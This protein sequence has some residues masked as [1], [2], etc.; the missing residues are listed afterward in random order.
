MAKA[1]LDRIRV[2]A[3]AC[4]MLVLLVATLSAYMRLSQAGLGCPNWPAC[5][6]AALRGEAGATTASAA[7]LA[8]ARMLHRLSAMTVLVLALT[9]VAAAWS[10]RPR[11]T[12]EAALA[13]TMVMVAVGL[14]VLGR[15]SAGAKLPGIA[16]GNVLGGFAMA[17]LGFL[18]WRKPP[19]AQRRSPA[20]LALIA[21]LVLQ[22]SSGVLV[23]ASYA[24]LSC[25]GFPACGN[26]VAA[27]WSSLDPL[28][29][30]D[31]PPS[32][33]F[34]P[35]GAFAHMLHRGLAVVVALAAV[36]ASVGAWRRGQTRAA[37]AL[38]GLLA[39]QIAMGMALVLASLPLPMA[40]LHNL[41]AALML[42]AA[43]ACL[44]P[45]TEP[46]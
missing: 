15:Y 40:L 34:H 42:L 10:A 21:L 7:P 25:P 17:S 36:F 32:P 33:P 11:L 2:L 41:V 4:L 1:P 6:G 26:I 37:T 8:I 39:L 27:T 9:M 3:L 14:A 16:I 29:M 18:L 19:T 45:A 20:A 28:R 22:I 5:Y 44:S 24:G 46:A 23:S 31:F 35:E 30:P 13:G 38:L 43:I 12:R